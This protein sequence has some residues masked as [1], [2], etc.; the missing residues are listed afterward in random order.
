M[1]ALKIST[2]ASATVV[3]HLR[4]SDA[5]FFMSTTAVEV[6]ASTMPMSGV[7]LQMRVT[8]SSA[9]AEASACELSRVNSSSD[10]LETRVTTSSAE[11]A[12]SV[13]ESES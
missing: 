5:I 10:M 11:A 2:A 7:M 4:Y 1:M 6:T 3:P 8:T 9:E 13:S 12:P